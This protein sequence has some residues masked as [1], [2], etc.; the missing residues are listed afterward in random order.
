M[1]HFEGME[2]GFKMKNPHQK[3]IILWDSIALETFEETFSHFPTTVK[4]P[5]SMVID[6]IGGIDLIKQQMIHRSMLHSTLK[7]T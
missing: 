3:I 2:W 6:G 4:S 7:I 5:I 1:I